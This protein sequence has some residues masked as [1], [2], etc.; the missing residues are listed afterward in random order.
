MAQPTEAAT[1]KTQRQSEIERYLTG[2]LKMRHLKL[3]LSAASLG[4]VS[5]VALAFGVS[6]PAISK[7][8]AEIEAALGMRVF[9]R[10]GHRLQLTGAGEHVMKSASAM[11]A[12]MEALA[13]RLGSLGEGM[14]GKVS[15]G[16]VA[17]TFVVFIPKAL[18]RFRLRAPH[19]PVSLTDGSSDQLLNA[20][21]AGDI[22]LFIGRLNQRVMPKDIRYE[23]ILHDPTV[24]VCGPSHPLAG[25]RSLEWSSLSGQEWVL[26][27]ADLPETRAMLQWLAQRGVKLPVGR[28]ESRSLLAILALLE[29]NQ[30]ISLVPQSAAQLY[31]KEG[32]LSRLPFPACDALGLSQIVWIEGRLSAAAQLLAECIRDVA[33]SL[34]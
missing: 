14:T 9:D 32:R 13:Q 28:V 11:L 18:A 33:K 5:K 22:D 27:P 8:I 24:I 17:T 23:E 6:Q 31:V 16:G 1:L 30:Y 7:Q 10:V 25:K 4:R 2:V 15:L 19:S 21:R 29:T 3:L 26:P 20:L 12:E 34:R